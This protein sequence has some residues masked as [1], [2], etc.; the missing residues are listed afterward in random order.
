MSDKRKQGGES[1]MADFSEQA[2]RIAKIQD[3]RNSQLRSRHATQ[4]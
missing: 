2:G 4:A 1:E 3:I